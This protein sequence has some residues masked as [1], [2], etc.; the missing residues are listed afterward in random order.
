MV[1]IEIRTFHSLGF[2]ILRS[3]LPSEREQIGL[4]GGKINVVHGK[5]HRDVILKALLKAGQIHPS[6]KKN[7]MNKISRSFEQEFR[8]YKRHVLEI[9]CES[10]LSSPDEQP[11]PRKPYELQCKRAFELYA[12]KMSEQNFID[13]DDMMVKS[14]TLIKTIERLRESLSARYVALLVD[15]FQDLTPAD[16]VLCKALVEKSRSLTMVGDDD[17]HIYSFRSS[18]SWFCHEMI[19]TWFSENLKV[20]QLPENRRCPGAIVRSATAVIQK[21]SRRAQKEII[22]VRPNGA[23]VR[24]V[25]CQSLELEMLFVIQRIKWLLPK[26]RAVKEQILVLFRTNELLDKFQRRLKLEEVPTSRILTALGCADSIGLKTSATFALIVLMSNTADRATVVWAVITVVPALDRSFV[27]RIFNFEGSPKGERKHSGTVDLSAAQDGKDDRRGEVRD[28]KLS[29]S[30]R[31]FPS[32]YLEV[33]R[34]WY[35]SHKDDEMNTG[36][37]C[38]FEHLQILLRKTEKLILLLRNVSNV[39]K[40]VRLAGEIVCSECVDEYDDFELSASQEE[41]LSPG[42][43]ISGGKAGYDLLFSAARKVDEDEEDGEGNASIKADMPHAN[44]AARSEEAVDE[45]D[46]TLLFRRDARSR[47]QKRRKTFA[48]SDVYT[49]TATALRRKLGK[50][51]NKLCDTLQAIL[52]KSD[53]N[54]KGKITCSE[55]P[56]V[57]LSTIHKAKGTSFAYVVLC[58]ADDNNLPVCGRDLA[59]SCG[60][61]DMETPFVE[62]ERRLL[63]VSLTRTQ[64]EFMC[65][66]SAPTSKNQFGRGMNPPSMLMSRDQHPRSFQSP[67]LKELLD[68]LKGD[69]SLVT[70]SFVLETKDME[71]VL[72]SLQ[73]K[74]ATSN[75]TGK[76]VNRR[77]P[78]AVMT[79]RINACERSPSNSA[80]PETTD[81]HVTTC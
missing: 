42:H 71:T 15:E 69:Q 53:H 32:P 41:E 9:E 56:T 33:L 14:I 36:Q 70:E 50:K 19:D 61:I 54:G 21:N 30:P 72:S 57:I 27:E 46:F 6:T 55:Q 28:T 17:Q 48:G 3:S 59:E 16:F 11:S 74:P 34:N 38:K 68:S 80:P 1:T 10:F 45:E 20:L 5:D 24:V 76:V 37:R 73:A 51:I 4:R 8:L 31:P 63:F 29:N 13:Y 39:G 26:V 64:R 81:A 78:K 67:F 35:E 77:E 22:A 43:I 65:T 2:W 49:A 44:R 18:K 62:E 12:Q 23:P 47:S 66:Y 52:T 58:G 40:V 25:G 60:S 79:T 75:E 7:V